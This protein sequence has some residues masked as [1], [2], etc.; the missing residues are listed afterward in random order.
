M[1]PTIRQS[2]ALQKGLIVLSIGAVALLS[3]C[4]SSGESK[5]SAPPDDVA[6]VD[7][8]APEMSNVRVAAIGGPGAFPVNYAAENVGPDFGL[9][10]EV[11]PIESAAIAVTSVVSG[12]V[13][14]G[15]TSYFGVIEAINQGLDLVVIAEGWQSSPGVGT[16]EALPS[17]GITSLADLE[18]KTV[19]VNSL[20][21]AWMVKTRYSMVK[22]GL[23]PDAVNWVALPHGEVAAALEQGTIDASGTV[24]ASQAAAKGMGSVT[25]LD[26]GAGQFDGMAET[27]WVVTSE[28][29]KA[30][31][32]TVAALQCTLQTAQLAVSDDRD[33]YNQLFVDILGVP[34]EVA[35][36]SPATVWPG[37]NR[38]D[39]IQLNADIYFQSG[40]LDQE[41]DF[42]PHVLPMPA[43]C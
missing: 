16:L 7:P 31:P 3:A 43:S 8:H 1:S 21:S 42:A 18:G 2:S 35:K 26:F 22:E 15:I 17:S 28:F 5:P 13:Q 4:A 11:V 19:N 32:N 14:T 39:S 30:N 36:A 38:V 20:T 33:L 6:V 41:F 40:L 9:A 29:A 27:G 23:D 12:D 24:G 34:A 25:I 10:I 37:N